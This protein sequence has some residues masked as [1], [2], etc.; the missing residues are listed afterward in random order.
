MV[1]I[2]ASVVSFSVSL[3]CGGWLVFVFAVS[4]VVVV[5]VHKFVLAES[6]VVDTAVVAVAR[7]DATTGS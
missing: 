2:I 7:T 3:L 1:S 5:V 6:L 4:V